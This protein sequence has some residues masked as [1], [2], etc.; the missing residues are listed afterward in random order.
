MTV[1]AT[2]TAFIG[3]ILI[4]GTGSAPLANSAVVV[5]D[6]RITWAGSATELDRPSDVRIVDISGKYLIPGLLD[7]N[8]HLLIHVDPDVLLRYDPGCY[9]ELVLEAAQVAL[10]AGITTVFD[11]WGPLESLRRVRDRINAR[12]TVGSRIFCA[13]NI[14]GN[15]GPYSPDFFP[16]LAAGL[17]SAVVDRIN[18]HW[19]QGVG[20]ELTWMSAE[21]V[22]LAVREYIA[23]AGIDFV[24][25]AASSHAHSRFIALSPDAQRA[26]VEEAHAAGMTAQA[27]VQSPEALKLAIEAGVDLLQHGDVTGLRPMPQETLDLIV[28]RRLPCAA[29]FYTR[30]HTAAFQERKPHWHGN[31]AW[32]EV[33]VVKEANDRNLVKAG[34]KLLLAN[35][36]G[37]YGPTAETSPMWGPFQAG[38]PDVPTHLGRSHIFWLRAAGEHGLTPM[39][40]LLATTSNIA[41]AYGKA[42]ELGTIRPGRRADLLILDGDPL[43]D[44][45]NYA[46]IAHIVKDGKFVHHDRLPEH[47]VL[48]R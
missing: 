22:R 40:A 46:R 21:D 18:Q 27:C 43:D 41:E 36:M 28:E 1:Q 9:D 16:D 32:G 19:E 44:P 47:P 45:E 3:A 20:A 38:I 7:A 6:E 4:D 39:D 26:I 37:V 34:A 2:R 11:T 14:I 31:N 5:E 15:G 29:F 25:Y 12:E 13:G 24:K 48:T 30:R 17:S 33:M 35:D 8:V 23:T 42:D 10:R